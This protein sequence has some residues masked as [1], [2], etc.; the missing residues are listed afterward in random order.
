[1]PFKVT[2]TFFC[3]KMSSKYQCQ[4]P[5]SILFSWQYQV[6]RELIPI[7]SKSENEF[8][9]HSYGTLDNVHCSVYLIVENV[10]LF[11]DRGRV[12]VVEDGQCTRRHVHSTT[13]Q[14]L[15]TVLKI[16]KR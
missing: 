8:Y 6:R 16:Q 15:E 1:M 9:V 4:A 10:V 5:A 14:I 13:S 11:V 7:R 2:R 12:G 3:N